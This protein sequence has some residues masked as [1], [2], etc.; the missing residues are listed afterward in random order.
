MA[1]RL[2]RVLAALRAVPA[3]GRVRPRAGRAPVSAFNHPAT[4]DT[5]ITVL[6]SEEEMET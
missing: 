5:G 4:P 2:E 3:D 1:G 6:F